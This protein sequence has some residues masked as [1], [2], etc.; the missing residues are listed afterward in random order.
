M[1]RRE[2]EECG[3]EGERGEERRREGEKRGEERRERHNTGWSA[4]LWPKRPIGPFAS[5]FFVETYCGG[6]S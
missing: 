2:R 5:I 4:Q 1:K 3:G 6:R